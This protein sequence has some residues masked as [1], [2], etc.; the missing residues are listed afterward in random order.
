[1]DGITVMLPFDLDLL[2]RM[3]FDWSRSHVLGR[4]GDPPLPA[5]VGRRGVPELFIG[6][7]THRNND[8]TIFGWDVNNQLQGD[9]KGRRHGRDKG[10]RVDG[11]HIVESGILIP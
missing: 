11:E 6:E 3:P 2:S 1:M 10:R 7:R 4:R 9:R 8:G 5:V